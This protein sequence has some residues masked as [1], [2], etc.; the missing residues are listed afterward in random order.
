[1][2]KGPL[3][4]RAACLLTKT[5]IVNITVTIVSIRNSARRWQDV[6]WGTK[7]SWKYSKLG[8]AKNCQMPIMRNPILRFWR[9]GNS[10]A[11]HFAARFR[12]G[13]RG[14]R[15]SAWNFRASFAE[16]KMNVYSNSSRS[17]WK[18]MNIQGRA[19]GEAVFDLTQRVAMMR[20]EVFVKFS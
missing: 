20:L 15:S 11:S 2:K 6:F 14:R 8:A 17:H 3:Q 4:F 12:I 18:L 19:K 9:S 5:K 1:M 10:L 7:Y 13:R 16:D